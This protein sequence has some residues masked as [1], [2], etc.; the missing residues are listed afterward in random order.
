MSTALCISFGALGF[1]ALKH[2]GLSGRDKA[3]VS[4]IHS[5]IGLAEEQRVGRLDA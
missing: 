1:V 3:G 4:S 2:A 5:A